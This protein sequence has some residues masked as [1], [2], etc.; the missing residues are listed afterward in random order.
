MGSASLKHAVARVLRKNRDVNAA[1]VLA[2]S[3]A[4]ESLSADGS[5][6]S[7]LHRLKGGP[8]SE[9]MTRSKLTVPLRHRLLLTLFLGTK[10]K[11]RWVL[12]TV[13]TLSPEPPGKKG[14]GG[15]QTAATTMLTGQMGQIKSS[16]D[17]DAE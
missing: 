7:G 14:S 9:V 11:R 4:E 10:P 2:C 1:V 3:T 5:C 6:T 13:R 17:E 8:N 12:G 16:E 15:T